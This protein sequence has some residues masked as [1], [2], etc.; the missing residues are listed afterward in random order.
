MRHVT[1]R[2]LPVLMSL[3]VL[4]ARGYAAQ[5]GAP[6]TDAFS[7]GPNLGERRADHTATLLA[8]GRLLVAGGV[9][10][11]TALA[12][13]CLLDPVTRAVRP[14]GSLRTARFG[15]T[16]TLLN[17]GRVLIAGGRSISGTAMTPLAS[18][19]IYEPASGQFMPIGNMMSARASHAAALLPNATVLVCGGYGVL[20]ATASFR[21]SITAEVSIQRQGGSR[22]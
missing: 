5:S 22:R 13:A 19:K 8:D 3:V 4:Q 12:S 10:G 7:S 17:D 6:P 16:A 11:L 9:D 2:L 1:W 18:T 21:R 20:G 14:T 15:H